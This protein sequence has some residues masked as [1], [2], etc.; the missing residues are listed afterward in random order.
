[1]IPGGSLIYTCPH[2]GRKKSLLELVSGNTFGS[3]LWSDNKMIAPMLPTPSYVQYCPECGRYFTLGGLE[4]E[5]SDDRSSELGELTYEQMKEAL[6]QM[7][8]QG[9]CDETDELN[10]RIRFIQS[11]NDEFA[12]CGKEAPAEEYSRFAG[13]VRALLRN[14]QWPKGHYAKALQAEFYREIGEFEKAGKCL[15]SIRGCTDA[16]VNDYIRSVREK[17]RQQNAEVFKIR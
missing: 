6:A 3:T 5:H 13:N 15:Y 9:F 4:P 10:V 12:R 17:V 14:R 7:N 8:G 1:M 2:C 11:Y 16:F